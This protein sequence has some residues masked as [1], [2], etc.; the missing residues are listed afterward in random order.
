MTFRGT[1]ARLLA[2]DAPPGQGSRGAAPLAPAVDTPGTPCGASGE[3]PEHV[4]T[5][6]GAVRP[7]IPI[8]AGERQ[9]WRIVN[10]SPDLYADLQVDGEQFEVVALD[11]MPLA[12]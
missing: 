10:A 12:Y 4:F 11:G 5:V 1:P 7:E 8:A 3:Q 9:F 2:A 6:N